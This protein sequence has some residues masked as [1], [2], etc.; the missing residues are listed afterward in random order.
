MHIVLFSFSNCERVLE[1][2][3][4]SRIIILTDLSSDVKVLELCSRVLY[5]LAQNF[6]YFIKIYAKC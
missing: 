4:I 6:R 5:I 1:S 3:G 2:D